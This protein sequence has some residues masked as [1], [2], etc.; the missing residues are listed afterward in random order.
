MPKKKQ[1]PSVKV[2][3]LTHSYYVD[4]RPMN[5]GRLGSVLQFHEHEV[6][7]PDP[8]EGERA[9]GATVILR[10]ADVPEE[11]VQEPFRR[12]RFSIF[13]PTVPMP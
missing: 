2:I 8:T 6:P 7:H 9:A 4:P 12:Y 5:D 1:A 10:V 11:H 13:V 3:C